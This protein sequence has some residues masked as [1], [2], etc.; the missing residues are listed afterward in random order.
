M[1]TVQ[2]A[3]S[4][5]MCTWKT[6]QDKEG[7]QLHFCDVQ[8]CLHILCRVVN[9]VCTYTG[10]STLCAQCALHIH[11]V[12]ND[13]QL[14]AVAHPSKPFNYFDLLRP[15]PPLAKSQQG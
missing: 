13:V 6:G 9:V 4:V 11:R 8:R 15:G 1:C 10:L 12:V 3:E 5:H 7:E 14:N 2:Y